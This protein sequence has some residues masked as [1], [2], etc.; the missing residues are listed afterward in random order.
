M[1][2]GLS[3]EQ[4]LLRDSLTQFLTDRAPLARVRRF[5]ADSAAA[6]A[7]ERAAA[8]AA[9]ADGTTGAR[10]GG[11]S[12]A[13]APA[14]A[15]ADDITAGLAELGIPALLIPEAHGGVG[16]TPL[17]AC[18]VAETLGY[19]VT[20]VA[21]TASSVM[22]PTAL[23]L[24]G[25]DAQRLAWLP[26][27]ASGQ[28]VVGAALAEQTGARMDA[29][30]TATD[31][32]LDGRA[33]FVLDSDADAWLVGDTAGGLHLVAA[34]APGITR[35]RLET[36]D[37]TR[38]I[39]ELVFARTPAERLPGADPDV[40]RQVLDLGRAM[41]AADTLGAAQYMLDQAVAYAK[42]REQFG[43][44]IG[45]FQ[46]V[47][48]LCAEMA[49][50]LEPTR[51]FVWY[52]GHQL[53]ENPQDAHV[54]VCQLKAHLSEVGRFVSKTATEVHG[55][56]GFTDL[57]GLHYWFKRIGFDRQMLGTPERLRQE[58]ARAQGLTL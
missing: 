10:A 36:V 16:L 50:H 37:A 28:T 22:V 21:F 23:R 29:G 46:A 12:S 2:F 58:A 39:G 17:D 19:H 38:P 24:A 55:G 57:L 49:A 31:G 45:S 27:I 7:A 6:A 41:L 47:K 15:R 44:V 34:D 14:S 11:D 54:T 56:M 26:R 32:R 53:G 5:A 8:D 18:V 4:T 51:A 13:A 52:A 33:L 40:C 25:S 30:V 48:H 20:P 42:Q 35:R 3:H 9:V 1:E 43:R